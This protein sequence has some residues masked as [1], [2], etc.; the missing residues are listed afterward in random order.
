[1]K[2]VKRSHYANGDFS[3]NKLEES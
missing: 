2:L 3:A 1:M